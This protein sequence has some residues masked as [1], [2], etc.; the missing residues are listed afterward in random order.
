MTRLTS[1]Q[2]MFVRIIRRSSASNDRRFHSGDAP[3]DYNELQ[4]AGL[5]QPGPLSEI[6]R[7]TCGEGSGGEVFWMDKKDGTRVPMAYCDGCGL[8]R[9]T[10]DDLYTWNIVFSELLKRLVES[11]GFPYP[12]EEVF[13]DTIWKF[14][15]HRSRYLYYVGSVENAKPL[16]QTF[17]SLP[18]ALILVLSKDD[19]RVL[20]EF[21]SNSSIILEEIATFDDQFRIQ[22]DRTSLDAALEPDGKTPMKPHARRG[23]RTANIEKLIAE[24]KQHLISARDYAWETGNL[25]PRPQRQELGRRVGLKKHDVTRCMHDPDAEILRYLWKL[26]NDMTMVRDWHTT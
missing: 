1:K 15:R 23:N 11:L 9:L 13:P 8:N 16:V 4:K 12:P 3:Q 17:Q 19:A 26:A 5:I 25:L 21:I 24:L 18:T 14:G 7:C 2:Q 20:R 6:Y 22:F 10:L